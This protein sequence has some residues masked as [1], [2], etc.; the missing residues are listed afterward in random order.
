[1]PGERKAIRDAIK[2]IIEG[3]VDY[4]VIA[5]RKIDGRDKD[6]FVSVYFESGEVQ[7]DGLI[8]NTTASLIVAYNTIDQLDD[9]LLDEVA[10]EIH[11]ALAANEIAPQLV[12][13]FIPTGWG[14]LD[15]NERAF[16]GIYLRYTVTY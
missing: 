2:T 5:S 9:D 8:E 10:D 1:M 6:D 13:G 15:D 4:E 3:V 12:Q 7:F 16:S 11:G 14:Y